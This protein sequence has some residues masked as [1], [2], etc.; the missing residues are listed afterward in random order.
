M[1]SEVLYYSNTGRIREGVDR[2]LKVVS[3]DL[4]RDG[5]AFK[6]HFGE[7]GNDTHI[8]P[9]WVKGIPEYFNDPVFVECNVMYRGSRTRRSDHLKMAKEH[10]FDFINIDI[11][12][13][14]MGEDSVDV[15]VAL[16]GRKSVK[17]GAGILKYDRL[18]A[19]SH[20]KGHMATGFGGALKNIGMGLGS[21]AG[22]MEMHS[23]ISP[24]V[25]SAKCT[26]CG[27][28]VENCDFNAIELG[29][30]ASIDKE[31]C[32]G[33]ARCIAVCPNGAVSIPW[34]MS[35]EVNNRLMENIADYAF[36]AT[37]GRRWWYINFL[38]DMTVD[39]DC[40]PHAQ[41]R[42]A[43][44]IGILLSKDPVAIDQASLDLI[45]EKNGKDPFKAANKVD[46]S[47]ILEYGESIGLGTR[48]YTLNRI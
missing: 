9:K 22:K 42:I 15:P 10:G 33:C 41:K 21:R 17:L 5:V 24:Y 31:K 16:K 35:D 13:G 20:F 3:D 26:A 36:G 30:A 28:C 46:S 44:D 1:K 23:I 11:L 27:V 18:V 12:D 34:D 45:V 14:E 39:C 43:D 6:I 47:H 19:L 32:A 8:R 40:M 37:S 38:T 7:K 29:K 48:E 4:G 2:F 25:D